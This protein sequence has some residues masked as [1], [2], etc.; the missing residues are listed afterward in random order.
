MISKPIIQS[1]QITQ[2]NELDDVDFSPDTNTAYLPYSHIGE[3]F[4]ET[5]YMQTCSWNSGVVVIC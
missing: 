3:Y 5:P 1:N 4:A 2:S